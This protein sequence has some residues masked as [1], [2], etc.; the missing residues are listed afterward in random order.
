MNCDVNYS[1]SPAFQAQLKVKGLDLDAKKLQQVCEIVENKSQHYAGDVVDLSEMA[2]QR[3]DGSFF[4]S[5][6]FAL[7]GKD[8]GVAVTK[9]FKEFFEN[10]PVNDVA[11]TLLRVFKKGK[12]NEI[13]ENHMRFIKRNIKSAMCGEL[14]SVTK[15]KA[16]AT[17]K[18]FQKA[19]IQENLLLSYRSR[20]NNLRE[21]RKNLE[22]LHDEISEKIIDTPISSI[23][24]WD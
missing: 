17:R 18:D 1:Y 12:A 5:T 8:V 3:D 15:F 13:F 14:Q 4:S 9:D 11:K 16:T 7:N 24:Y 22:N 2:V 23:M 20:I 6:N 21:Q 10:N 19:Q